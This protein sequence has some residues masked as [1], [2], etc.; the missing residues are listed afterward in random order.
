MKFSLSNPMFLCLEIPKLAIEFGNIILGIILSVRIGKTI[1]G[2]ESFMS[3]PYSEMLKNTS[4]GLAKSLEEPILP[5]VE[6]SRISAPLKILRMDRPNVPAIPKSC[7]LE[8]MKSADTLKLYFLR[9][10]KIIFAIKECPVVSLL[11]SMY[12]IEG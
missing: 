2:I 1:L 9:G 12:C 6:I 3:A 4:F 5:R 10:T 11:S 7:M 8:C